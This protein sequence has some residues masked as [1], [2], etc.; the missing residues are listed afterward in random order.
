MSSP[1]QLQALI[2]AERVSSWQTIDQG[3]IDAFATDTGDR[4]WLHNDPARAAQGPFGGTI[5]QGFLQLSLLT[6]F[7]QE[8]VPTIEGVHF[9]LNYGFDKVR[10][11][12]PVKA[13]ARIRMRARFAEARDKGDGRVVMKLAVTLEVEGSSR[14]ALAAEWLFLL[15]F[16]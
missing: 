5:A 6:S 15:A 10:F 16:A 2:G 11:L 4:D 7:A 12:S 1:P 14:P 9:S 13:G 8:I 3:R